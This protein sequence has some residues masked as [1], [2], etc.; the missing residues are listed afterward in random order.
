MDGNNVKKNDEIGH[1]DCG[2]YSSPAAYF[3]K[4]ESA[5]STAVARY[6]LWHTWT[7]EGGIR[8]PHLYIYIY[9]SQ[10]LNV[11]MLA[12]VCEIRQF[13]N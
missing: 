4:V 3:A 12:S 5:I 6:V 7:R 9:V 1:L 13:V 10:L 11:Y 2:I 8:S